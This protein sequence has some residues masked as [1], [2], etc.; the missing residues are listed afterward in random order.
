MENVEKGYTGRY[1]YI[2]SDIQ[3]ATNAPD[4]HQSQVILAERNTIQGRQDT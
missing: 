1:N 3:A 2:L 4:F